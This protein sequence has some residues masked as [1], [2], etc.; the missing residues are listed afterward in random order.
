MIKL[1]EI[2][3]QLLKEAGEAPGKLELRK[4]SLDEAY[5]YCVSMGLKDVKNLRLHLQLA[6]KLFEMGKT[7]RKDMPVIDDKDVKDFQDKLK[8]GFI[9]I[10]DPFS[11]RT[12]PSDPFPQGLTGTDAANF[13]KNGLHDKM[14]P[15]DRINVIEKKVAAKNLRPIQAQVYLSKSVESIAHNGINATLSFLNKTTLITSSDYRIIDGHHRFLSAIILDPNIQLPCLV[16]DLPIKT[17]LPVATAYGD[18]IG[19]ERNL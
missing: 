5:Q 19:N 14:K 16:V 13:M 3:K 18:A 17:L 2:Y 8:H 1:A 11:D 15:D 10:T 9:D 12:D 6:L 4:I 7:Q